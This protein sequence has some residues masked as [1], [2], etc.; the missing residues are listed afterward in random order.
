MNAFE[1][2]KSQQRIFDKLSPIYVEPIWIKNLSDF[3]LKIPKIPEI[4]EFNQFKQFDNYF[5]LFKKIEEIISIGTNNSI[6]KTLNSLNSKLSYIDYDFLTLLEDD[7]ETDNIEIDSEKSSIIITETIRVKEIISEIY[8]NNLK[9]FSIHPR[10][11]EKIIAELLYNQGFKVELT[12]Q[13]RDNGY[14]ILALKYINGFSPIKYLVEC[15]RYAE[16]RKI[17][18]EIIRSFK[19]VLQTENANKGIIVT[20]SY[21]TKDAIKK[22][23]E[24]PLLLDYK[25]KDEVLEWVNSYFTQKKYS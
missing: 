13:T 1:I 7:D 25:N 12:K 10:E 15:K 14:D 21:F 16:D 3:K 4:L 17:G 9:L 23:A 5:E 19:E 8:Y 6:F 18:V 2:L 24:T 20:T 22:Q 11:F